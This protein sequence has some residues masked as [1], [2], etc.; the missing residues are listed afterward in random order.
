MISAVSRG[1]GSGRRCQDRACI[2]TGMCGRPSGWSGTGPSQASAPESVRMWRRSASP[3]SAGTG[4]TGTPAIRHPAMANAVE[5]VGVASTAIRAA[6]PTRSATDVAAPTTSLRLSVAS[7]I[8]MAAPIARPPVTVAGSNELSSTCAGY[9]AGGTIRSLVLTPHDE[10][11]AVGMGEDRQSFGTN[12]LRHPVD[13][14][15][16]NDDE[17]N[18]TE[19]TLEI[20]SQTQVR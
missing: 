19:V 1:D 4:T 15:G 3:T 20:S 6:P 11:G 17:L 9:P 8:R 13:I 18:R 12:Q 10:D 2:R 7:P 14:F 5:A 16:T